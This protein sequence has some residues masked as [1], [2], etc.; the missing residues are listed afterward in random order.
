M[1]FSIVARSVDG[2]H[3]GVA[4]AS[5]FVAVGAVVP[6]A[7]SGVGALATQAW[8]NLAYRPD[9]LRLLRSGHGAE[10]A[11]ADLVE[12]DDGRDDRQVGI[13][14]AS[15]AAATFTG[16]GCS[17]WAGGTTG[18]GYSIQGNI[19]TGPEVVDAD[20]GGLARDRSRS[21]RFAERLLAALLAGDR[22]RR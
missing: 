8:A 2:S 7:E 20:G 3:L 9:G 5:K 19:L 10:Q 16:R 22:G 6:A 11:L 13:V 1:T 4:V 18:R 15:G 14:D 17:E 21:H 12:G